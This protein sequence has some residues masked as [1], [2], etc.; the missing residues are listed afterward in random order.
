LKISIRLRI[1]GAFFIL[2]I[3]YKVNASPSYRLGKNDRLKSRKQ[4]QELFSAGK[5]LQQD[6]IRL[7]YT[8]DG[9]VGGIRAGVSVSTRHFKRAVD[10]NRIKRLMR[11]AYRL[12]RHQ[13]E[14]PGQEKSL[15]LFWIYQGKELPNYTL[16]YEA[17]GKCIVR[18][19]QKWA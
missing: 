4:I 5:A 3:E 16:I 9:G 10:R 1:S 18:L 13:L 11:E 2:I 7:I 17:I 15:L 8:F 12:Q 6:S 14:H 19:K